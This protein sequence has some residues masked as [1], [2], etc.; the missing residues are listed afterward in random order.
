MAQVKTLQAAV[1][2][3][4][5][6]AQGEDI[7]LIGEVVS[8][9]SGLSRAEL[10]GTVC[11]LLGWQRASGRLKT[12]ECRDLLERLNEDGVIQLPAKASG[13][14]QGS[15]S[16]VPRTVRGERGEALCGQVGDVTPVNVEPVSRRSDHAL[17]RELM[18]RYHYLGYAP[19]YGASLRYLVSVSRPHP[20]VV[21]G[22]Q[23]SSAAW[24][25][26]ARDQWIGWS[27]AQRRGQLQQVVNQSRFLILPWIEVS[28][29]ASHILSLATQRVVV[30]W[31]Q[32][33]GI[34]P[35]LLE[36]LV[37]V[38]RFSGTCYRAA[39]WIP[40]GETTGRGRMDRTHQRHGAAPKLLFVYPLVRK[41]REKL[42]EGR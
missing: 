38:R 6:T 1:T 34:R 41:A 22:L 26:K 24:R 30:D 21:G 35:L 20:T 39:N 12:R 23:F 9:C 28:N 29:L 18:G 5:L 3:S 8:T 32:R 11:E 42:R 16:R 2:A 15:R 14:P 7:A 25:M 13:R 17:W 27:E 19:A 33:F 36:T 4:G 31:P 40:L 37:D 10:A